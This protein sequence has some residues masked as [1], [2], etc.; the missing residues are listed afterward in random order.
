VTFLSGD[1]IGRKFAR[2]ATNIVVDRPRLWNLFRPLIRKQFDTLAPVWDEMR[3]PDAF[4]PHLA[5]LDA[6]EPE[7]KRVLDLGTGTG[8]AALA[9]AKRFPHAEVVGADLSEQMIERARRR[10]ASEDEGRIRFE[11]ADAS[12]L[13]YDDGSFDLVSLANMIPFFDELARVITPGGH[14]LMS[15]SGGAS[16]PIYVPSER[17]RSELSSRGF[18]DFAD[19]EAGAGTALLARKRPE[20]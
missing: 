6:I 9:M 11:V 20:S 8:S 10:V 3:S 14:V 16:T 12:Q 2:V 1:A 4:A 18:T 5:A 17:L 7:P 15:F 13:P 19:F